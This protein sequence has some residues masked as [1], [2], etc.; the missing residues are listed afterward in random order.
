MLHTS[1]IIGNIHQLRSYIK[2]FCK[3]IYESYCAD[4]RTNKRP[5]SE[6]ADKLK[7]YTIFKYAEKYQ[8]KITIKIGEFDHFT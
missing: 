5:D 6:K 4:S 3:Y 7:S 1:I 8:A 2:Y